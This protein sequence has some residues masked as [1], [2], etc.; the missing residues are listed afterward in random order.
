MF[1]LHHKTLGGFAA[2]VAILAVALNALWPL[3]AQLQP[4]D[5]SMQMEACAEMGVHHGDAGEHDTAPAEPSPLMPHCAFC[6]L[7]VGGFTV[8]AA[9]QFDTSFLILQT[10]E[11][12]QALPEVR[13]LPFVRFSPAQ[14]RAP[15][16]LS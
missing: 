3:V 8:L 15:P 10:K 4:G 2:W 5:A 1:R 7:V 11:V 14:P 6:S 9:E 16:A 13:L 12:R